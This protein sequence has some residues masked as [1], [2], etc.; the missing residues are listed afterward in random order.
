MKHINNSTACP[1]G[2]DTADDC[3][4]CAY[5]ADYHFDEKS[6]RCIARPEA[7]SKAAENPMVT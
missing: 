2:G 6:G 7:E 5:S 4:G 1:L 3:G